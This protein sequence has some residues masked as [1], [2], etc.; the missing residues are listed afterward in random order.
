MAATKVK[1]ALKSVAVHDDADMLGAG[2]W[3]FQCQVVRA[4]SGEV[5]PFGDT[6]SVFEVNGGD[7]ITPGWS[8]DLTMQSDDTQLEVRIS[9][10]D[11]DLVVDDDLGQ[12]KAF[13]NTP[14]VHGYD[15]HLLSNKGN[16]TAN[17]TVEVLAQTDTT[18]GPVTTI[19]QNSNSSTYNSLYDEMLS[20]MVHICPVIPV[21]WGTGIPPI[22]DGVQ[23]LSA[24]PQENLAIAPGE[25]KSNAL[26]NPSLI[27][28]IDPADPGFEDKCARIR[29]TQ[30]RPA[31]LDLSKLIWRATSNVFFWDG[32]GSKLEIKGG[33]E[34]RCYGVVTGDGDEPATIEVHWDS[35]GTPLLA[36]FRAWVGKPRYVWTRANII[37][38]SAATAGGVPLKNPSTSPADIKTQMAYNNIILWQAGIQMAA[39][40]DT[41]CYNGAVWKDEGIFEVSQPQN[42]TFNVPDDPQIVAPLLNA[43]DRVFN[44]AYLHSVA[45]SPTLNGMATD[46]RTSPPEGTTQL[47]DAPSASWVAPTGVFPDEDA[48][49]VTMKCMGPSAKRSADQKPLCGDGAI[50]SICGCIMTRQGATLAGSLTLAHELGHVLGLHHRGCGGKETQ[51]SYDGVDHKSGLWADCGHP[52]IENLLTYGPNTCRQD[53]DL[54]QTMRIR[55]HPLV[56]L[57]PPPP[58]PKPPPPGG[59]PPPK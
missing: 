19:V 18:A 11:E 17:I 46:R 49:T 22:A 9:G 36:T 57:V 26:V 5:I 55:T 16:Y 41:T 28:D 51:H 25:T 20:K 50:D 23:D 56:Q 30:F 37:R 32:K 33:R 15:L 1:I 10:R 58:V 34:V 14:I 43:R 21:P 7:T 13:L 2:E 47:G 6:A 40:T 12:V 31:D 42:Y 38:C 3:C 44:V 29:I 4:P 53:I 27:P 39:D 45:G 59:K 52:W 48:I 35:E 54:I 8:V 24:S